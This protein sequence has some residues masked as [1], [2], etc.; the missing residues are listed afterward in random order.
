MKTDCRKAPFPAE[1]FW[2]HRG[3]G[4]LPERAEQQG[5]EKMRTIDVIAAVLVIV[6][7]INWGLVGLFDFN[8]VAFLF[9]EMTVLSRVVYVLVGLAGVYEAVALWS[10]PHRWRETSRAAHTHTPTT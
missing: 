4:I 9:G 5:K 6:G 7:A 8:L 3:A 10:M 1:G 2:G